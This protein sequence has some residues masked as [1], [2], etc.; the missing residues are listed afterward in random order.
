MYFSIVILFFTKI[1]VSKNSLLFYLLL[2]FVIHFFFYFHKYI[3]SGKY[4][5]DFFFCARVCENEPPNSQTLR[6]IELSFGYYTLDNIRKKSIHFSQNSKPDKFSNQ[7]Q[8]NLQYFCDRLYRA[9]IK[10]RESRKK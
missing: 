5:N 6:L 9:N 4:C 2:Y 8:I 3:V 7:F 10:G 1:K